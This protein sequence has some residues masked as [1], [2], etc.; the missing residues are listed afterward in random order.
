MIRIILSI[1]LF[2]M[3]LC[4]F[5]QHI[6]KEVQGDFNGKLCDIGRGLCS[7]TPPDHANK[8][9]TMKNYN[10][11]KQS[12]NKMVIELDMDT[13]TVQNQKKFFGKEYAKIAPNEELTFVQDDDFVFSSETLQYLGFEKSL[14]HL[15][16]GQYPLAIIKNRIVI[17]LTLS[18]E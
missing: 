3:S 2:L 1:T 13:I 7:I 17:T 8:S 12:E 9:A 10:T 16:K 15:K 4:T 11:Y 14:K 6:G 5:G 18:K